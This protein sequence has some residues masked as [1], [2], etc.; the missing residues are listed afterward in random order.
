MDASVLYCT[1]QILRMFFGYLPLLTLTLLLLL[2]YMAC[3]EFLTSPHQVPLF[4]LRKEVSYISVFGDYQN[5]GNNENSRD[6]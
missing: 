2:L 4:G 6:V 3:V 1:S 5:Q